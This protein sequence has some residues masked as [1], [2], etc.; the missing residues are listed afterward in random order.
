MEQDLAEV[1]GGLCCS[2]ASRRV[3]RTLFFTKG[4]PLRLVG[5]LG[6]PEMRHR[7]V[8]EFHVD[9]QAWKALLTDPAQDAATRELLR[10][11]PFGDTATQQ[12]VQALCGVCVCV[13]GQRPPRG[14]P[15]LGAAAAHTNRGC[16]PQSLL[17]FGGLC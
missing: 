9:W 6:P 2:L 7:T 13:S 11:S 4:W 5:L 15:W 10:R 17:C 8:Q 14:E 3:V 1:F 16:L 12:F